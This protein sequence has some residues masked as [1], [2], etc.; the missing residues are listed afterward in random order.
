MQ[1]ETM[2]TQGREWVDHQRETREKE[3]TML[4]E[5]ANRRRERCGEQDRTTHTYTLPRILST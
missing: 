1:L 3:L 2:E 5:D 4:R